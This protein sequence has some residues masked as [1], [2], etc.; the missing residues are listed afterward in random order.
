MWVRDFVRQELR[1]KAITRRWIVGCYEVVSG[2]KAREGSKSD[3]VFVGLHMLFG[4]GSPG[5]GSVPS[6]EDVNAWK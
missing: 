5:Y 1:P 4:D 2:A 6:S 3:G